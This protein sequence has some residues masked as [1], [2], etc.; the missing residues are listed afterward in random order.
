MAKKR[1]YYEVLGS[2]AT[3]ATRTSRGL[4]QARDEAPSRPQPRQQGSR[5][6]VQG[7][8]GSLR[9]AIRGRE[10]PRL[11]RLW[12]R[13]AR[14]RRWVAWA[15][16]MRR[17]SAASRKPSATSSATSS[18]AARGAA[19]RPSTVERTCAT[20]SRSRSSRRRAAP[21]PRS[22]F[23]PWRR[24]RPATARAPSPARIRRRARPAT[25]RARCASRRASSRSSRP[26]PRA[27]AAAR[28]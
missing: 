15:R 21:R 28:W 27:T 3:R 16:E 7:G 4:S 13:R 11:R 6:A 24:A 23:R 18:A 1:D 10:A 2:T 17:A 14:I 26:A 20:T 19:G 25:A 9:G 5:G 12:P 8:E 22:A